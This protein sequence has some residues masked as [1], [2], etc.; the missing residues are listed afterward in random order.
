MEVPILFY[1]IFIEYK[2][3]I[4]YELWVSY[5]FYCFLFSI[6][7]HSLDNN[8]TIMFLSILYERHCLN[9]QNILGALKQ[10]DYQAVCLM[11][12]KPTQNALKKNRSSKKR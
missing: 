8:L 11:G 9:K 1:N 4:C 5:S 3:S 7:N 2:L 12:K 10:P 6:L